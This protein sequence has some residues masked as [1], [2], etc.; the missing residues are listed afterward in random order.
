M[1]F[2][3]ISLNPR[4][5]GPVDDLFCTLTTLPDKPLVTYL[6]L[7]A[8]RK[9]REEEDSPDN[10]A[11]LA[12]KHGI[13]VLSHREV[14]DKYWGQEPFTEEFMYTSEDKTHM[15]DM[16][17]EL[18]S[19]IVV[20]F[21]QSRLQLVIFSTFTT[22]KYTDTLF[23]SNY[24]FLTRNPQHEKDSK[25]PWPEEFPEHWYGPINRARPRQKEKMEI[26]L[27]T[28]GQ[29]N[30]PSNQVA[31]TINHPC[32]LNIGVE[33]CELPRECDEHGIIYTQVN[34][35]TPIVSN[36]HGGG[37]PN[38][39]YLFRLQRLVTVGTVGIGKHTLK[40]SSP[41]DLDSIIVLAGMYCVS[42]F[43]EDERN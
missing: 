20:D 16:G 1:I 33:Q 3:D 10:P 23:L 7:I 38:E 32:E 6:D 4:A 34:D 35:G 11:T 43:G 21:L 36:I 17:H 19:M 5:N 37:D 29:E 41:G 25:V 24:S 2:I 9:Q 26:V 22:W 13:P 27:N 39:T 14:M 40:I 18:V 28:T 15:M 42:L 30:V 12:P 8:L 31:L